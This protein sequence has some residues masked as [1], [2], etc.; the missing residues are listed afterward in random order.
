MSG[1]FWFARCSAYYLGE[2]SY[3]DCSSSPAAAAPPAA[4]CASRFPFPRELLFTRR[5]TGPLR[6]VYLATQLAKMLVLHNPELRV[7][8]HMPMFFCL[9]TSTV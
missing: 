4:S 9:L 5:E 1:S 3:A 6:N 2:R 7:R 8:F